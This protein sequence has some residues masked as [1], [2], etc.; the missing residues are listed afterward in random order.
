MGQTL[1]NGIYL[2]SE[3]ER[4]CYDGL[5]SNWTTLDVVVG[6]YRAHI[7]NEN[8]HI[9]SAERSKWN[10]GVTQAKAEAE[11]ERL[12]QEHEA[13]LDSFPASTV[14]YRDILVKPDGSKALGMALKD[15]RQAEL[16]GFLDQHYDESEL[17]YIGTEDCGIYYLKGYEPPAETSEQY[18]TRREEEIKAVVQ[19][20][21]DNTAHQKNYDNGVYCTSYVGDPD[22][23][24]DAQA[25]AFLAWRGR[26]WR[27]CYNILNSVTAGTVAP[28]DVTDDYVRERLPV[29]EWPNV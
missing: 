8:I 14:F 29:M 2:P 11:Q 3:G 18:I 4:N 1:E 20:L 9:T 6:G 22:P 25:R 5:A 13:M 7:A 23:E 15:S 28:E 12:R 24:F 16:Y 21:I 27:T 26:C 17:T 10:I 19:T